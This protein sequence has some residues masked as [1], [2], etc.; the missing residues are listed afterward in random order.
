MAES[1]VTQPRSESS[2][3]QGQVKG[4]QFVR[5]SADDDALEP[6]AFRGSEK[7]LEDAGVEDREAPRRDVY[8][9]K[10]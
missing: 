7:V 3:P 5:P 2:A 6:D 8:K 1:P 10:K 9:E 4:K